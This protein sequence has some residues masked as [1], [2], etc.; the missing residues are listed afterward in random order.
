MTLTKESLRDEFGKNYAKHY[1]VEVFRK[2]GFK[3][4]KCPKCNR[5]FWS[6]SKELCG[7]SSCEPYSFFA[8][9]KPADYVDVWKKFDGY[10]KKNGHASVPR[11]P[12]ICRWREDLHFT[13]A[14]IVDFM[15]LERGKVVFEYPDTTLT[16][17]QMCLRFNDL[18]N[19]GVT[20]RHFS[21]FMMAGQHSFNHP[22]DKK[23][24]WKDRCIEL[25]YGY[26]T[27]VLGI[28]PEKLSYLEDVW[29][30]PDLSSF[31]P[32]VETFADG[33]ELVNSVFMQFTKTGNS[34]R[35]LD[36]KVIDV[37]WGFERLVWY[38]SGT[39]T[40][41]DCA[42][43]P[44]RD[45]LLKTSGIEYDREL[46]EKLAPISGE[47]DLEQ[48]SNV[49]AVM[50]ALAKKAGMGEKELVRKIAPLQALYAVLDHSRALAFTIADRG[51]PSNVGGGY[52]L[53]VI[54]RRALA[55]IH[56]YKMNFTLSEA[57][58]MHCDYLKPLYPELLKNYEDI[59]RVLE[60]EEKHYKSAVQRSRRIV[61][62]AVKRKKLNEKSI[63]T[64][65]ESHG[66]TPELITEVARA[67]NIEVKIPSD[68]YKTITEQHT[69][70]DKE[71]EAKKQEFDVKGLK[72]TEPLFYEKENPL[73]ADAKIVHVYKDAVVLDRTPFYPESGGQ[74]ADHG[75]IVAG[76]K[77]HKVIDVQKFEGV[78]IHR[79]DSS[80][81]LKKGAKVRCVVDRPRRLALTRHHSATH[82]L[83]GAA[84]MVLGNHVWQAGAHKGEKYATLDIT[85]YEKITP[86]QL[87]EIEHKANEIVMSG[88]QVRKGFHERGE[89]E[90]KHGFTLYQGGG[91][92]GKSVRVVDINGVD[93]Q[94][95]GGT[96][97]DNVS[98]I[99][100]IKIIGEERIQ[101]GVS[102]LRFAAGP[103]AL[104]Y[105]SERDSLLRQASEVLRVTPDHLPK[106]IERFFAE[107]KERGKRIESL[108]QGMIGQEVERFKKEKGDVVRALLEAEPKMLAK[109]ALDIVKVKKAV[110]LANSRGDVV[111]AAQKGSG[112]DAAK[113]LKE[114]MKKF[115]G[116]G[117]GRENLAMGK[118]EKKV[119]F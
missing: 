38:A 106:S 6:I 31:G 66:I 43:G 100:F 54:L 18:P 25:N 51:L 119:Q 101:D 83:G 95:C 42:F 30:M 80:K 60:V 3:R 13:I 76:S 85:H 77:H 57:V 91:S 84:R 75:E 78:I 72:P 39:P 68:F 11:Y 70:A 107:W 82:V 5:H 65:Y 117:G 108:S 113:M 17:P 29:A 50:G 63:I 74:E 73:E 47:V 93:T 46:F 48:H 34:Y 99:G 112:H 114:L 1:E 20:G 64:L 71:G 49:D 90:K 41:Y 109:A 22:K 15:R 104:K 2:H 79:L 10:F 37:G 4:R 32:C 98:E 28:K 21:C 118:L 35:E 59:A 105:I 24:Y 40:A 27:G 116:K 102:R 94:A 67:E 12:T 86:Q 81:G 8:K 88:V 9:K 36:M 19:V 69:F 55:F 52:N 96:H 87:S 53:R 23:A 61:V 14:S 103:A 16:V 26:L 89:A 44:V 115:G 97:V 56:E 110:V 111:C 45:R 33:I 92:P 62:D 58:K 7:D